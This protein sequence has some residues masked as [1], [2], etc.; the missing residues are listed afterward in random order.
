LALAQ[1]AKDRKEYHSAL[2]KFGKALDKSFRA[3]L[4]G[5]P[6][7]DPFDQTLLES[8]I[9]KVWR[10]LRL[11]SCANHQSRSCDAASASEWKLRRCR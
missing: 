10:A 5:A 4:K 11:Q 3:D 8:A 7:G 9:T 2:A 6:S 1:V